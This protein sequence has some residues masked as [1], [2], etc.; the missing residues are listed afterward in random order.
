MIQWRDGEPHFRQ[1]DRVQI[2]D[3]AFQGFT[4]AIG[5]VDT[6]RRRLRVLVEFYGRPIPVSVDVLQAKKL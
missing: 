4:G 3:G 5:Q 1:G 2:L 6:D